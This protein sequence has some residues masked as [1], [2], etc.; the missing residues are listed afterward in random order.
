[1]MVTSL[2]IGHVLSDF[3]D[4]DFF[5]YYFNGCCSCTRCHIQCAGVLLICSTFF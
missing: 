3:V 5:T 1:M 4:G 2:F